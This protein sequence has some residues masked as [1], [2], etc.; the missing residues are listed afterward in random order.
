MGKDVSTLDLFHRFVANI[1]SGQDAVGASMFHD[2]VSP[3]MRAWVYLGPVEERA[4]IHEDLV[5]NAWQRIVRYAADLRARTPRELYA[6]LKK[7]CKSGRADYLRGLRRVL[8]TGEDPTRIRLVSIDGPDG[9]DDGEHQTFHTLIDPSSLLDEQVARQLE[10]SASMA[11]VVREMARLARRGEVARRQLNTVLLFH[12]QD[13]SAA[14]VAA[15][16]HGDDYLGA[17]PRERKIKEAG[18]RQDV[19][20]GLKAIRETIDEEEEA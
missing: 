10:A 11:C 9:E 20:R 15:V 1:E 4:R 17:D 13:L 16:L 19:F 18:I 2:A 14:E 8:E 5:Q 7:I 12:L 3:Q 6:W